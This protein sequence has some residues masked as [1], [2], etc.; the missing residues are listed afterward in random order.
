MALSPEQCP[1]CGGALEGAQGQVHATCPFCGRAHAPARADRVDEG[2]AREAREGGADDAGV[3]EHLREHLGAGEK[4]EALRYY[5]AFQY[6][7]LYTAHEVEDLDALEAM[8]TPLL[9]DTARQLGVDYVAP[10]ARGVRITFAYVDEL[11]Q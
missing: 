7:V 9:E 4:S 10:A 3:D 1:Q 2:G 5:E 8:A 6:L 11:L